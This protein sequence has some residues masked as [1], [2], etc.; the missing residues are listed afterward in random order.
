VTL[1][2]C[3]NGSWYFE[4]ACHVHGLLTLE[5]EGNNFFETS[6]TT[7]SV[8]KCHILKGCSPILGTVWKL[9][10][11]S[12]CW[13]LFCSLNALFFFSEHIRPYGTGSNNVL[14]YCS[15]IQ[16][17]FQFLDNLAAFHFIV[18]IFQICYVPFDC[19][20]FMTGTNFLCLGGS[21]FKYQH[22]SYDWGFCSFCHQL[23]HNTSLAHPVHLCI[24]YHLKWQ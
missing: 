18:F 2:H 4:G 24:H 19:L 15:D 20:S 6:G 13:A 11:F 9:C 7:H 1:C 21:S 17:I 22:M 14:F 16:Q 5:V 23:G 10:G 3:I 12:F 8:M